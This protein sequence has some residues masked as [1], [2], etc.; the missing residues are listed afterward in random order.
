MFE[1]ERQIPTCSTGPVQ[2]S[3]RSNTVLSRRCSCTNTS[4][5]RQCTDCL[6]RRMMPIER[7][8]RISAHAGTY[9]TPKRSKRGD[10]IRVGEVLYYAAPGYAS[11]YDRASAVVFLSL[12]GSLKMG[13]LTGLR[14]NDITRVKVKPRTQSLA[15]HKTNYA[16]QPN[17]MSP[18]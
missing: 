13:A 7:T 3:T 11:S 15:G 8:V 1:R 10:L 17:A 18:F 12:L 4:A 6:A 16:G 9:R 5:Y 14:K 2:L